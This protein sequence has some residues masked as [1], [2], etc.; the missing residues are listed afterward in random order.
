MI[1]HNTLIVTMNN[2]TFKIYHK[3]YLNKNIQN[4][5]I[6]QVGPK[7]TFRNLTGILSVDE[8]DILI[9]LSKHSQVTA[10]LLPSLDP[11]I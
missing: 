11:K 8:T 3:D 4:P 1:L 6:L 9:F 10:A 2:W 7:Q 5:P